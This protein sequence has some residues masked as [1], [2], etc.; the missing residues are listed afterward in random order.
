M[1]KFWSTPQQKHR[2]RLTQNGH[3]Y[4]YQVRLTPSQRDDLK[5]I[6]ERQGVPISYIVRQFVEEGIARTPMKIN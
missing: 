1:V 2:F 4:S 5:T 3:T 6:S